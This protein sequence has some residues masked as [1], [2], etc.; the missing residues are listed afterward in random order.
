M[1]VGGE[2]KSFAP[3]EIS[4]MVLSKMKEVAEAYLG[5]KIT[6]AVIT[7]PAYFDHAQRQA[8]K[9]AGTISGGYRMS[10]LLI[11]EKKIQLKNEEEEY[12][13]FSCVCYT[14]PPPR[15]IFEVSSHTF[16]M[17]IIVKYLFSRNDSNANY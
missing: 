16:H 14:V 3:E 8:T 12:Q 9:D 5:K 11:V 7:V 10:S 13:L 17:S 6:H 15:P 2:K 1:T 4:A